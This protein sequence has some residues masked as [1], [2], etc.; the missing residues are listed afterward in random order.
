MPE[1]L[2][3]LGGIAI[4]LVLAWA[5]STDHRRIP[6]RLVVWGLGL[7]AGLALLL[8]HTPPG[9][10]LFEAVNRAF[11][12]LTGLAGD[13]ANI[14]FGGPAGASM[15]GVFA[16]KIAAI[17]V[18]FASLMS[19][20]YHLGAMQP[21]VR[22]MAW[23]MARTL[24]ISGA[25]S[26]ACAANVFIGMTE[27]PLVIRPYLATLTRSELMTVMSGGFAT[28]AGSVMGTYILF[29]AD[30]G[31]L[32]AA[33]LMSAP[34]AVVMAK[35]MIPES[36][37]PHTLGS[38]RLPF[39]RTTANVV[40]AAA[41][42]AADGMRLALNVVA[43]LL[44]F[45]ALVKGIDA[46][47]GWA[48]APLHVPPGDATLAGIFG[49]LFRPIAY[50][51]GAPPTDAPELAGLLGAQVA[52]NEF[53][54]Y[55]RLTA[56]AA[57]PCILGTG[58]LDVISPRTF[59][60]ATYALCGFANFGSVAIQIGGIGTLAPE[61][62]ADLARL[63]LRAMAAGALACWLTACV[64][65]LLIS[66]AEAAYKHGRLLIR[67]EVDSSRI[68]PAADAAARL[69]DALRGSNWAPPAARLRE[70]LDQA[71][72]AEAALADQRIEDARALL[73]PLAQNEDL[74]SL[75]VW[76]SNRLKSQPFAR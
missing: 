46:L 61:R 45:I 54:A 53:V 7:Q 42:G 13:S 24:R 49:L 6:W 36:D 32:L 35:I 47:L 12:A 62:R 2:P 73:L 67:K 59:I 21:V 71:R 37:T 16:V 1:R 33:S 44:A 9:R 58:T 72:Q 15:A 69:E 3:S 26:L 5:L 74:P 55:Q 66:D 40:D 22:G 11:L 70:S 17:I 8:F 60:I 20:L 63:G 57:E 75:G 68:A 43:M 34:A 30:A 27:A 19:V 38:V 64:A 76:A 39:E 28:I 56:L 14:V 25:E 51:L 29:G 41:T 48:A 52:V 23:I 65:G 10:W 18:F 31:H 50:L 4:L